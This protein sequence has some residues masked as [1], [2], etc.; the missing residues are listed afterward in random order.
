MPRRRGLGLDFVD[1]LP[2]EGERRL[3]LA[4]LMDAVRT[5]RTLQHRA[6]HRPLP[7]VKERELRRELS[8]FF[9][10]DRAHPFAFEN[11][12]EALGLEAEYI[13][14]CVKDGRWAAITKPVRRYAARVEESWIRQRK[15]GGQIYIPLP[16]RRKKTPAQSGRLPVG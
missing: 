11:I 13:R 1:A 9:S 16:R 5:A 8:W 3:M 15:Y 14:R 2:P 4:V 10:S 6:A 7:L 12:C